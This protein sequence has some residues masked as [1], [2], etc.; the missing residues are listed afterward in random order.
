MLSL[1]ATCVQFCSDKV[2]ITWH[3]FEEIRSDKN[4]KV[5]WYKDPKLSAK[6]KTKLTTSGI[7]VDAN[8]LQPCS[9]YRIRIEGDV[10]K[11]LPGLAE[12]SFITDCP[13]EGGTCTVDRSHGIAMET[14]FGFSCQGWTD[15]DF[16]LRYEFLI[17]E[18]GD[19]KLI[20]HE[21]QDSFK[22]IYLPAGD[23]ANNFTLVVLLRVY[24]T[25]KAYNE[26]KVTLQV[27]EIA[28]CLISL[29]N[30]EIRF[31]TCCCQWHG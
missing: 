11:G 20:L 12:Y 2:S 10:G 21:G 19:Y 28:Y 22:R 14:E 25:F 4:D 7:A 31:F 18:D 8:K 6:I 29:N 9:K 26:T 13:P 24:D 23:S 3:M 16:P 15:E 30:I 1:V 17:Q 5:I 27:T